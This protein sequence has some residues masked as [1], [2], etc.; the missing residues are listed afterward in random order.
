MHAYLLSPRASLYQSVAYQE[1]ECLWS[2]KRLCD[3]APPTIRSPPLKELRSFLPSTTAAHADTTGS[4]EA[5]LESC[6]GCKAVQMQT[7]PYH[8]ILSGLITLEGGKRTREP[9][10]K[11]AANRGLSFWLNL[12][13]TAKII[14]KK[15]PHTLPIHSAALLN[16]GS[17]QVYCSVPQTCFVQETSWNTSEKYTWLIPCTLSPVST[18]TLQKTSRPCLV[19]LTFKCVN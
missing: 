18:A 11:Q 5:R 12:E 15:P 14:S 2:G 13:N 8:P 19:V 6:C 3:T 17:K 4:T 10:Y 9:L 1:T 7:V 16:A